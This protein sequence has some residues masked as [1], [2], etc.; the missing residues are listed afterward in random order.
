MDADVTGA[1]ECVSYI[2]RL[3]GRILASWS[4]REGIAFASCQWELKVPRRPF[5]ISLSA[6]CEG[7]WMKVVK[8]I[9]MGVSMT[10]RN[11]CMRRAILLFP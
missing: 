8:Y 5:L 1:K 10:V 2:G 9:F 3:G 11:C 6:R 4:C 7:G